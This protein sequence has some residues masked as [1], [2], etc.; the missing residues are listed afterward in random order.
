[1]KSKLG[2]RDYSV[3]NG[4]ERELG[5]SYPALEQSDAADLGL[6]LWGATSWILPPPTLQQ[7]DNNN[8]N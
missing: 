1:M 5:G 3:Y 8:N 2:F 7:L 6:V 4:L